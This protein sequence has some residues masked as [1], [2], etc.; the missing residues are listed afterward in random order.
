MKDIEGRKPCQNDDEIDFIELAV[1]LWKGRIVILIFVVLFCALGFFYNE[2]IV[3]KS[4]F[5]ESVYEVNLYPLSSLKFCGMNKGCMESLAL[6]KYINL[7]SGEPVNL[8]NSTIS[9]NMSAKPDS[10]DVYTSKLNK[11]NEALTLSFLQASNSNLMVANSLPSDFKGTDVVAGSVLQAKQ[12]IYDIEQNDIKA[13]TI[14]NTHIVESQSK[15]TLVLVI[16]LLMGGMF[17]VF[18]VI[19][20]KFFMDFKA[21]RH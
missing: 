4:Y 1:T 7:L 12:M 11:A 2:K 13:L 19:L 16:S 15:K 9:F 5:V 18:I 14:K 21:R 10:V 6:D 20:K 17:G 8:K 3:K